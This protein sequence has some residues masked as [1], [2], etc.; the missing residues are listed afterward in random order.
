RNTIY[1]KCCTSF[2]NLGQAKSNES[3]NTHAQSNRRTSHHD[4]AALSEIA[5][6]VGGDRPRDDLAEGSAGGGCGVSG[7]RP[8]SRYEDQNCRPFGIAGLPAD[9]CGDSERLFRKA[10]FGDRNDSDGG[11]PIGSGAA[12]PRG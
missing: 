2:V 12:Q 3:K 5:E 4:K 1:K 9:S 7:E 8:S 6:I 11:R 10:W